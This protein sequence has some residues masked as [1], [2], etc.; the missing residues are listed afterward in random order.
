MGYCSCFCFEQGINVFLGQQ[1]AQGEVLEHQ[2]AMQ[3]GF[4]LNSSLEFQ[5]LAQQLENLAECYTTA[6][7]LVHSTYRYAMLCE[8]DF[9]QAAWDS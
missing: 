8:R 1:L 9:F 5:Q 7:P 3:I 6:T 4:A 2:Y